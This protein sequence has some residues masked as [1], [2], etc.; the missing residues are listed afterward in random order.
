MRD[1]RAIGMQGNK[2]AGAE[3]KGGVRVPQCLCACDERP[4]AKQPPHMLCC[5]TP[6]TVKNI[7]LVRL[8]GGRWLV[9]EADLL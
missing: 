5:W 4:L 8:A 7:G 2:E 9:A 3:R 1:P 6:G